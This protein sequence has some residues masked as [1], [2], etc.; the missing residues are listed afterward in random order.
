MD[1]KIEVGDLVYYISGSTRLK[2]YCKVTEI[3]GR[4][5]WGIWSI[6][7]DKA[8]KPDTHNRGFMPEE[9]C[10]LES[11]EKIT[12]WRKEFTK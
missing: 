7:K 9:D 2:H 3:T 8:L 11:K 12:N 4:R 1:T 5:I 10:Y 6:N